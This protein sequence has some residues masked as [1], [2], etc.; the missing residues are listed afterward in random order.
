MAGLVI[1]VAPL[2]EEWVFR[3]L[4]YNGLRT[5]WGVAASTAL[6]SL[7]FL[8][9]HPATVTTFSI[10]GLAVATT[11]V[12]EK[13]KRLWPCV[14]VHALYNAFVFGLWQM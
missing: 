11:L 2:F 12:M 13:T 7:L 10:V 5:S 6:T 4:I 3:A 1:L 9:I 8:A 14:L